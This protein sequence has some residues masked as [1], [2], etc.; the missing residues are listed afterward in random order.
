MIEFP[1]NNDGIPTKTLT[2]GEVIERLQMYA[3]ELPVVITDKDYKFM[4]VIHEMLY[5][6]KIVY[7]T[8]TTNSNELPKELVIL[9]LNELNA[10][11]IS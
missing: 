10:G 4:A 7:G 8:D 3:P 5:H 2:V 11:E 6:S 9:D 1:I